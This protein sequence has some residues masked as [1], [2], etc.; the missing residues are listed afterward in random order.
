MT[1]V[2]Q[3][4]REWVQT[5]TS[6]F[7]ILMSLYLMRNCETKTN[8][9]TCKHTHMHKHATSFE[10]EIGEVREHWCIVLKKKAKCGCQRICDVCSPI[11]RR[12][13]GTWC[14]GVDLLAFCF[15]SGLVSLRLFSAGF[16]TCNIKRKCFKRLTQTSGSKALRL[17][18]SELS[19]GGSTLN[20]TSS[21]YQPLKNSESQSQL[22]YRLQWVP[23]NVKV[24]GTTVVRTLCCFSGQAFWALLLWRS[25]R[26]QTVHLSSCP[27][28]SSKES[29]RR[30]VR[31]S[32]V[33]WPN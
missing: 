20:L 22:H 25:A 24:T 31:V 26:N 15:L 32:I 13:L 21:Q 18:F 1:R 5:Y 16:I 33:T 7:H 6:P 17:Y 29:G 2:R 27:L 14:L 11:S 30:G 10:G 9:N 19:H 8:T 12:V 3:C 28:W 4:V 23:V